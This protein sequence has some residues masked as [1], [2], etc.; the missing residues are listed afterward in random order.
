MRE[1]ETGDGVY[2]LGGR[3]PETD[4]RKEREREKEKERKEKMK[5]EQSDSD[6]PTEKETCRVRHWRQR[7][8]KTTRRRARDTEMKMRWRRG[9]DAAAGDG[10]GTDAGRQD[11]RRTPVG[12]ARREAV[13]AGARVRRMDRRG[14][15]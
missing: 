15:A 9:G 7:G 13:I 14:G 1:R 10:K 5:D 8:F 2:R 12:G 4:T 6:A 11:W 3:D